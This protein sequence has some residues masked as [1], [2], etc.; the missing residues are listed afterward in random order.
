MADRLTQLQICLDQLVE[1]FCATLHYVDTHHEFKASE[2]EEL[3]TDP[4]AVIAPPEEFKATINELST[5]LILKTRQIIALIDSLPGAGVSQQEQVNKIVE[6]QKELES[7]EAEKVETVRK[8]DE[9][10][11]WCNEL[12]INFSKSLIESKKL[13]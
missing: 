6:L 5:D 1:Q 2:G 7:V 4:Q 3:M 13:S 11:Q 10:L 12:V 8:K 9:L